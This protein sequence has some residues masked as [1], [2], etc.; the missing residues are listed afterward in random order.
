MQIEFHNRASSQV[1][2]ETGWNWRNH[3][4]KTTSTTTTEAAEAE[5]RKTTQEE[6]KRQRGKNRSQRKQSYWFSR[7][8]WVVS[9]W[10]ESF[11]LYHANTSKKRK[12]Q[13][14]GVKWASLSS[15]CEEC[16]EEWRNHCFSKSFWRFEGEEI[17]KCNIKSKQISDLW[18][19]KKR[20]EAAQ[21]KED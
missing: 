17:I 12:V 8:P 1:E 2:E 15:D 20:E 16:C 14:R 4:K 19:S 7:S 3:E 21:I 13:G 11:D 5:E 10:Q 18:I 6:S 9:P